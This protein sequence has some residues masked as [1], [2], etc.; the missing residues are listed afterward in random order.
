MFIS[1]KNRRRLNKVMVS[2]I[3]LSVLNQIIA[4]TVVFALTSGPTAPEATSFEPIDTTDMVNPLNGDFTYNLPLL[5]VPGPEG[6]YPLSLS[7]H[8]GI[9][10]NEDASWVGLGW[11]LNPGAITRNVNGFPDDWSGANISRRD[12]WEGGIQKTYNIGVS[13]G[14]PG[15]IGNVSFGLSFSQDTYRGFGVGMNVGAS[16]DLGNSD[17]GLSAGVGISPFGDVFASAGVDFGLKI[18][19]GISGNIGLG[20]ATNF[21]SISAN[22]SGGIG[23]SIPSSSPRKSTSGSLMGASIS[24]DGASPSFSSGGL[25]SSTSNSKAGNISTSSSGFSFGIPIFPGVNINLGFSKVRYWS[26]ETSNTTILGSLKPHASWGWDD[27]AHDN[28]ALLDPEKS[29]VLDADPGKVQGGAFP[30][31]DLYSVSS[32]GLSGNIRPYSFQ[33][34]LFSQNRIDNNKFRLIQYFQTRSS[35]PQESKFRFVNDFSNSYRQNYPDYSS[36]SVDLKTS[37]PPFDNSPTYGNNDGDFGFGGENKLAGSK[38]IE[39]YTKD[40]N[41]VISKSGFVKPRVPSLHRDRHKTGNSHIEGFKITNSSGVTYHYN[42]PVYSYDEEVYQEKTDGQSSNLQT[43][44]EGYAYTWY[45]TSITGPDYVDRNNN[46]ML[47]N[48]DWGYWINF[49]YGLWSDNYVWRNPSEGKHRD[50]DNEFQNVSMGKKEIYYLNA[51]RTRSHIAFF[52]KDTRLDGKGG[53][54]KLFDKVSQNKYKYSNGLFDEKSAKSMRLNKIYLLKSSDAEIF[55]DGYSALNIDDV[56][57]VGRNLL[58]SKAIRI[59]DFN[60]TYDLCKGTANSFYSSGNAEKYGKLTLSSLAFRGIGG[61]NLTPPVEFDYGLSGS[62]LILANGSLTAETFLTSNGMFKVGDLIE[63]DGAETIFCG[64]ILSKEQVGSNYMYRFK[65]S[66]FITPGAVMKTVRTTKNP[67]YDKDAYDMWG[68]Y[69]SDYEY[70]ANENLSR[71]T[72]QISNQST[73]VWSLRKIKT[74]LGSDIDIEYEGDTYNK[75]VLNQNLSLIINS[76]SRINQTTGILNINVGDIDLTKAFNIGDKIDFIR[77]Q[78]TKLGSFAPDY[79]PISSRGEASVES[80]SPNTLQIKAGES[81][82]RSM[83]GSLE[84]MIFRFLTGNLKVSGMS[85][86]YGGGLRVKS[87]SADDMFGNINATIYS[88]NT[89]DTQISSGVTSYEPITLDI[90]NSAQFGQV[91]KEKY[92]RALYRNISNL[93][94]IA[95]EVPAAGVMY[96]YVTVQNAVQ[97]SGELSATPVDGKTVYQYEVFR[98]NMIGKVEA[99]PSMTGSANGKTQYTKNIILKKFIGALGSIKKITKYDFLNKKLS[100]TINHYLHDGLENLSFVDFMNQYEQRLAQFGYQGLLKE[101]YSEVKEVREENGSYTVRGTFSAREEYPVVP[102]GQSSKDYVSGLETGTENLGF[103]FYSGALT[104]MLEK[105]AY[106]NRF[107]TEIVPAYR[108]YSAMGLRDRNTVNNSYSNMLTQEASKTIYKVNMSNQPIGIVSASVQTWGNDIRVDD[109]KEEQV[110]IG[111]S[112]I[113]RKKSTYNWMPSGTSSDNLTPIG[114]FT[115]YNFSGSNSVS[116]KKI[117]ELTRYNVYSAALE[118]KDFNNQFVSTKMGY[119]NSKVTVT[120]AQA[121]YGEIAYTGAEDQMLQYGKLSTNILLGE[122]EIS[123][124]VAHT[125]SNS[126]SLEPGKTGIT[127]QV[128]LSDLDPVRRDYQCKVWVKSA[129]D[130]TKAR[131][132]YKVDNQAIVFNSPSFQKTAAGWYLLEMRVPSSVLASGNSLTV[133]CKNIGEV[134]IINFDDFRFQPLSSPATS[135]V[136]DRNTGELTYII[137]NNNLYVKYEYDAIGRLVKVSKEV[138]GKSVVPVVKEIVYN[139]AKAIK[140]VDNGPAIFYARLEYS[141]YTSY[142]T[143]PEISNVDLSIN[144]YTDPTCSTPYTTTQSLDFQIYETTYWGSLYQGGGGVSTRNYVYTMSSGNSSLYLGNREFG[145]RGYW[146]DRSYED[147]IFVDVYTTWELIPYQINEPYRIASALW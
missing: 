58:E 65:K 18:A 134:G 99:S 129:E 106:G 107:L 67:P 147:Y 126:I 101:R 37:S 83:E 21:E 146:Y 119:Q 23:Y 90:D 10:P 3:L 113:W 82:I 112:G 28:Y 130:V 13:V 124:D 94:S 16:V 7:Y 74:S 145:Q 51:I 85:R 8:A 49:E 122:G 57:K 62:D 56:N 52:E 143:E 141:N 48:G 53:S 108:K 133:G 81:L 121:R 118:A 123:S 41:G 72:S 131:M 105:D 144:L 20:V 30:D 91:V 54:P 87:I 138:L 73:D 128:P 14:L 11:T 103:D 2:F 97:R 46:Q 132:F 26:D 142:G 61:A 45:L 25:S 114:L 102:L 35:L 27:Y 43:R 111:Q 140:A 125:G 50:E 29:I 68:T 15:P 36:A 66:R 39:F 76:F 80:V 60:Y 137:D 127:Y 59:I 63:T 104:K 98:E 109:E 117:A 79:M 6:G 100:E 120:A 139:H 24:S 55:G 92:R 86:F 110:S 93:Y 84:T 136:Y 22:G 116:W 38:S 69:K 89:P 47:D 96:E 17:F 9:Q 33:N 71:L 4:P 135:Y 5:E 115:A 77:L 64:V 19:N 31:F 70:S 44:T 75:S 40:A 34:Q 95:R 12:F 32:Q 78:W 42:L 1:K 88:Y